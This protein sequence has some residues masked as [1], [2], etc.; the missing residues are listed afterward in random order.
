MLEALDILRWFWIA[1]RLDRERDRG[2]IEARQ[3]GLIAQLQRR[4]LPR[5]PFY[6]PYARHRFEALPLMDKRAWMAAF[7]AINTVGIR[8]DEALRLAERAERTRDFA[9]AIRG[10]TVGLSTGTSGRRGVFLVSPAERRRWAGAMLAKLLPERPFARRRVAFFLRANSRLYESAG[11]FRPIT[12]RYFDLF[13]PWAQLL[14]Q[15]QA[16]APHVLIAPASALRMLAEQQG[17]ARLH[18]RPERVISVAETL[19]A[20][21][22]LAIEAAFDA[23]LGEVYQA[24]EGALAMT[25]ERGSLHLNEA[26]VHVAPDWID[27]PARR[28]APIVTDLTRTAQPV[29]RYRL[30]DVLVMAE[31]PCPCGRAARTL[32]A[33]EGR[34]DDICALV[35]ADGTRVP[36]FPDFLVRAV[37][38][39]SPDILD[40]T[41]EQATAGAFTAALCGSS[42]AQP[43]VEAAVEAA[44]H[45]LAHRLGA[46]APRVTFV[47]YTPPQGKRRRVVRRPH[48]VDDEGCRQGVQEPQRLTNAL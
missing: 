14:D 21:D 40:F 36:V 45:D 39:A 12:F 1:R 5:S 29:V 27:R 7:D 30:D 17:A 10:V 24:T 11:R 16:Y 43:T 8:H 22:R 33:V 26:F 48:Q 32:Q 19:H 38:G 44:L 41:L 2:R 25:C 9:P 6:A 35:R 47:P 15:V 13:Q 28:F 46:Q 3:A 34:C 37:L 20:D 23:P 4:I 31:R 42:A 18:L